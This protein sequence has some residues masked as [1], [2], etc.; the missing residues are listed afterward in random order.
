MP[1]NSLEVRDLLLDYLT[2]PGFTF[3]GALD[4][5]DYTG[6][7][8]IWVKASISAGCAARMIYA[9]G[10]GENT[11]EFVKHEEPASKAFYDQLETIAMFWGQIVADNTTAE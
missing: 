6:I 2:T 9:Y 8:E 5:M 7:G 10:T 11:I 4:V 1:I 3:F